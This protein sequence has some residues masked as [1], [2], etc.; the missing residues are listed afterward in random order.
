MNAA[1]NQQRLPASA[2]GLIDLAIGA[3]LERAP[4]YALLSLAL[5]ALCWL[6]QA[7]WHTA[8]D[9][10]LAV[11]MTAIA[12]LEIAGLSYI[13]AVVALAVGTRAVGEAS[14]T[15]TLLEAGL[16]RY[17]PVL[18]AMMAV[19]LIVDLTT[20]LSAL[21]PLPDQPALLIVTAPLTWFLWGVLNLAGPYAALSR[22]R[23]VIALFEAFGHAIGAAL[24][25][26]NFLRLCLVA[27]VN[28][29]PNLIGE[30]LFD[31]LSHRNVPAAAFWSSVPLDVITVAPIAA[32]QTVFALDF[33]RRAAAD[34]R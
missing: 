15:R 34:H 14:S 29:V 2:G 31:G 10:D 26:Q 12:Y 25:P 16:V 18:A 11:K 3:V 33:A 32:L 13:I 4:L 23:A 8:N 5:F 6:V 28:V 30:V 7:L 22:E 19:T 21:G 24:R 9:T 27:F 20:P 1:P 17:L